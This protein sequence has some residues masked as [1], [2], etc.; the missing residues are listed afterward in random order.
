M[1]SPGRDGAPADGGRPAVRRAVALDLDGT[2]VDSH[3]AI[4][5]T[6]AQ[7]LALVRDADG[8]ALRGTGPGEKDPFPPSLSELLRAAGALGPAV[9]AEAFRLVDE[10]ERRAV[11]TYMP[12]ARDVLAWLRCQP[13]L[14]VGLLTNSGREGALGLLERLEGVQWFDVI[15]CRD[16]VPRLKPSP[17]GLCLLRER[18]SNPDRM[19]YVGDSWIDACAAQEAKI[20]FV[21]FRLS[22]EVLEARQLRPPTASAANW[23]E[24]RRVLGCWL[25]EGTV[26]PA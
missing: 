3:L 21:A 17:L 22:A 20:P 16:D 19:L 10:M 26:S 23:S 2:V 14:A 24:L 5:E 11:P 8:V 9:A 1:K 25:D 6:R 7:V 18:L 4:D 13:D 15:L 12:G